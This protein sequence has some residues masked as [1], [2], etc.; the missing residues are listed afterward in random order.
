M[1]SNPFS[2]STYEKI[3]LNHYGSDQKA[4]KFE[5]INGVK[6]IK[7]NKP[8]LFTNIGKNFTNGM[9]Y[10]INDKATDYK[11]K[12]FVIYDV[13]KYLDSDTPNDSSNLK[14]LKLKQ[15]KGLFVDITQYESI[16]DVVLKCYSSSKSRYNFR[17]SVKQLNQ[18]HEITKKMFFGDIEKE[19]Y[20]NLINNFERI[21][22]T[23]FDAINTHNTVLPMWDFYKE[24]LFPMILEKKVALFVIYD[25]GNPIAMSFNFVYDENLVVALRTFDINYSRMG[26][27]NIEIYYLIEWCIENKIKILDF[28]KGESDYKERWCDE[29]YFYEHHIIYDNKSL[30]AKTTAKTIASVYSFK[31]YLRDKN[32]NTMVTKWKYKLKQLK[33]K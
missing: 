16:D 31:Q 7:G 17:R 12:S 13:P 32:I 23:R 24:V 21:L 6:F 15:Y 19:E 33:K 27:G 3:W 10:Q 8:S 28:S 4:Q 18:K 2:S 14:I 9:F 30:I 22:E 1:K 20:Y 5:F 25:S 29:E 11:G 26:L